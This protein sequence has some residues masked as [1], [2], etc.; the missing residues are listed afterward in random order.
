MF[1]YIFS[2]KAEY[3]DTDLRHLKDIMERVAEST[4]TT[5]LVVALYLQNTH[6]TSFGTA[7]INYH[8][9]DNFITARGKW[10]FT[11]EWPLPDDLPDKYHLIRI[12]IGYKNKFPRTETDRYGWEL[13]FNSVYDKAAFIFAHELHHYRRYHLSLHRGEGEQ[14][15]NKWAFKH[16]VKLGF[17]ISGKKLPP[18]RKHTKNRIEKL[19]DPFKKFRNLEA[20]DYVKISH[21][22][23]WRYKGETALVLKPVRANS[24]R[25]VIE[26]SDGKQWRW[27]MVWCTVL[28][29]EKKRRAAD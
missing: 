14:S 12:C 29:S 11:K 17:L 13:S 15:A 16:L 28:K 6:D 26:T 5:N 23:K 25:I 8:T 22:P 1:I 24:K 27:P 4:E 2:D 7:Y 9:P 19:L 18:K 10:K 20:G 3:K 21:D